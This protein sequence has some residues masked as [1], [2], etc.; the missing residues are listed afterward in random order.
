LKNKPIGFV[1]IMIAVF[2]IVIALATLGNLLVVVQI[3]ADL[4][5]LDLFVG[6][7]V[8]VVGLYLIRK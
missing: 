1:L 5:I 6:T 7:I 4:S 2:K 8:L 3:A